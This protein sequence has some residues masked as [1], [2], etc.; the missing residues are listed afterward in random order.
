MHV[1]GQRAPRPEMWN[2]EAMH[3]DEAEYEGDGDDRRG[4]E[5]RQR[6]ARR[7]PNCGSAC[8]DL[9]DVRIGV[10]RGASQVRNECVHRG[11]AVRRF[12]FESMRHDSRQGSRN[13]RS[14]LA[15]VGYRLFDVAPRRLEEAA[16]PKRNRPGKELEQHDAER[17]DV[18]APVRALARSLLGREVLGAPHHRSRL[19]QRALGHA[20]DAEVGDHRPLAREQDVRRLDVTMNDA[21]LV[22]MR[23][24]RADLDRE[25]DGSVDRERPVTL[26]QLPQV[27]V[28]DVFEHD[29]GPAS[30]LSPVEH[31][32]DVR[33]TQ[34]RHRPSFAVKAC[35]CVAVGDRAFVQELDRDLPPKDGVE[36]PVDDR[37]R[38]SPELLLEPVPARDRVIRRHSVEGRDDRHHRALRIA[39]ISSHLPI[40]ERPEMPRPRATS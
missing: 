35:Q 9:G 28:G 14:E 30:V 15:H 20:S 21:V 12:L 33:M 24:R 26:D 38:T 4:R 1:G 29:V 17:V 22:G 18:A 11:V 39:S 25:L 34:A 16:P 3:R 7:V 40:F 2:R 23:Q 37:S 10:T 8:R 27:A 32:E 36:G 19:S 5:D 6:S 13:L 31:G